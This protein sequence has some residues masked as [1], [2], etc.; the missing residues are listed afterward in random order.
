MKNLALNVLDSHRAWLQWEKRRRDKDKKATERREKRKIKNAV[1]R[2]KRKLAKAK[3]NKS[4]ASSKDNDT[5][6]EESE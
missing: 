3:A 1:R 4:K 2:E 6:G 5:S